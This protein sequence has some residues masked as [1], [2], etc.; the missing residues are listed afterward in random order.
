MAC[1]ADI[2]VSQGSVATYARCGGSFSIH[3]TTQL[4]RNFP[5]HFLKIGS[6]Y[7]IVVMNLRPT[8]LAH[9]VYALH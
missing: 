8:F 2:D 3:L 7:R 4:P 5:L 6:D 1:F 9:P